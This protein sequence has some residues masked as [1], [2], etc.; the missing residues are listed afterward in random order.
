MKKYFKC[1]G[2]ILLCELI[3]IL[4]G[5]GYE[6]F[7]ERYGVSKEGYNPIFY[8][9]FPLS[10]LILGLVLFWFSR[11][12]FNEVIKWISLR[13]RS[14]HYLILGILASLM[15]FI[16][17]T[18]I[19]I[20]TKS[21]SINDI[22]NQRFDYKLLLKIFLVSVFVAFSEELIYR[23]IITSFFLQNINRVFTILFISA[24][25]S[26]SHFN[27]S[28]LFQ[29]MSAFIMGIVCTVLVLHTESLFS[30]IGL[31]LGWNLSYGIFK[32]Y[33]E[34]FLTSSGSNNQ[35]ELFQLVILIILILVVWL[36]TNKKMLWKTS[37]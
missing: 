32:Y 22:I 25:F 26:I 24:F 33:F 14:F 35:F 11:S 6:A 34:S 21:L 28:S 15:G 31:H 29:F 8:I 7:V 36:W 2:F 4:V 37:T 5:G 18:F 10:V 12:S 23:G 27:Y 3:F 20:I 13:K 16:I 9:G 30:A 1:I 19:G 17:I